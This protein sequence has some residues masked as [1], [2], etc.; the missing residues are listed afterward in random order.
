MNLSDQQTEKQI[1]EN[2]KKAYAKGFAT[3]SA[4]SKVDPAKAKA[5][6]KKVASHRE[7]IHSPEYQEQMQKK[8]KAIYDTISESVKELSK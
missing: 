1:E 6:F 2:V 8:A 7:T 3:Q 5:D 4:F